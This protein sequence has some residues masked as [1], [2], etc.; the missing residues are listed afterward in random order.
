M[1]DCGVACQSY[2]HVSV[3]RMS[4]SMSFSCTAEGL[5]T[6][7]FVAMKGQAQSHLDLLANG[8][9][10]WRVPNLTKCLNWDSHMPHRVRAARYPAELLQ[11]ERRCS[12]TLLGLARLMLGP[13]LGSATRVQQDPIV[14]A[15]FVAQLSTL[16]A[17][18]TPDSMI[19]AHNGGGIV[20]YAPN[21]R[22]TYYSIR[23]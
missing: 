13:S 9:R 12:G 3:Q 21:H 5:V 17:C 1:L 8:L 11:H 10:A 20:V 4:I 23:R 15:G 6:W 2:N 7:E 18:P 19:G 16:V 22:R 14:T